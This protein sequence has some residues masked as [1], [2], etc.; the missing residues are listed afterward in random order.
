[1]GVS[2]NLNCRWNNHFPICIFLFPVY[3]F[4]T[5]LPDLSALG[6]CWGDQAFPYADNPPIF[7]QN[8][9]KEWLKANHVLSMPAP[10]IDPVLAEALLY[11]R[12]AAVV[13]TLDVIILEHSMLYHLYD[14]VVGKCVSWWKKKQQGRLTKSS[15]ATV[16]ALWLTMGIAYHR[17]IRDKTS[18]EPVWYVWCGRLSEAI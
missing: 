1:M 3:Y 16:I 14:L 15:A 6:R 2:G 7:L 4:I 8:V 10:V 5:V 12:T 18:N 9:E 17:S 13:L 11:I